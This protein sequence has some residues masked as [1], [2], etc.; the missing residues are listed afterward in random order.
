MVMDAK[1]S[2]YVVLD[3]LDWLELCIHTLLACWA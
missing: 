3:W 1:V 2:C